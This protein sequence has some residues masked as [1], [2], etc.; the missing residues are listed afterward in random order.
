MENRKKGGLQTKQKGYGCETMKIELIEIGNE[1][2]ARQYIE[3]GKP[4][5]AYNGVGLLIIRKTVGHR[6]FQYDVKN[7]E[8]VRI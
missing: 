3:T 6:D 4:A 8:Y 2:D 5:I 7:D 1:E